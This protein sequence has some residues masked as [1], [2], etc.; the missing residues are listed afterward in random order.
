M[1]IAD[2]LSRAYLSAPNQVCKQEQEFIRAVENVK[3]TKHLSISPGRL[4]DIQ[5]KTQD[6]VSLQD[7]NK[8]I[9]NGWPDQRS[10]V[11]QVYVV[12]NTSVPQNTSRIYFQYKIWK[13]RAKYFILV[14]IY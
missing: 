12:Q 8:N 10:K 7:L 1:Q 4:L 9:E 6:D 5:E 2:T 13:K 3:M 11:L 14:N